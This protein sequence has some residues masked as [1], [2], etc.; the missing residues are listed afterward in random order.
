MSGW[1]GSRKRRLRNRVRGHPE[2]RRAQGG[3]Q[4]RGQGQDQGMGPSKFRVQNIFS[5][6][7]IFFVG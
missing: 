6:Y 7:Q 3:H 5:V 2:Q 4:A 1:A